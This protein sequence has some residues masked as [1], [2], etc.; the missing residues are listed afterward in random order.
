MKMNFKYAMMA[1]AISLGF[2][3]C[4]DN[5]GNVNLP[6]EVGEETYVQF[7][8]LQD[9]S[10]TRALYPEAP[11]EDVETT[12]NSAAVF[13]LNSN[14]VITKVFTFEPYEADGTTKKQNI[15]KATTGTYY[16]IA[17]ANVPS[18][19]TFALT[20]LIGKHL[21]N[22]NQVINGINASSFGEFVDQASVNKAGKKGNFFMTSGVEMDLNQDYK[23]IEYTTKE[24]KLATYD[25]I[26]ADGKLSNPKLNYVTIRIG[27]GVAKVDT[28]VGLQDDG[29]LLH[30]DAKGLIKPESI[31][32]VVTNNPNAMHFFP[33]FGGANLFQSPYHTA[34]PVDETQPTNYW[35]DLHDATALTYKTP[36]TKKGGSIISAK[37][38][39]YSY[40]VENTNAEPTYGNATIVSVKAQ[41][42]PDKVVLSG[43]TTESDNA[44]AVGTY[45]F[46][47]IR[48]NKLREDYYD[49]RF[50]L[51]A[52]DADDVAK[53]ELGLLD[54]EYVIEE[55]K[56]C[57]CY[58]IIPL[59]DELKEIT[60]RYDIVRNHYYELT[61]NKVLACGYSSPGG[62]IDTEEPDPLDPK[63]DT[64]LHVNLVVK[65]WT[66]VR[67]G[68]PLEPR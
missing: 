33:N 34:Y 63:K 54:G 16:F 25:Q 3:S 42:N 27:R 56:N 49:N 51:D 45:D 10:S 57:Y 5:E 68:G 52:N 13:M 36:F 48:N 64:Y 35:P 55:Y 1:A 19:A 47:R 50:F 32:Y 18:A 40:A 59:Y 9:N 67:Q 60:E 15:Y 58:Y 24:L 38:G 61:I 23:Q 31:E 6:E 7:D 14:K 62:D 8:L 11:A 4:S 37:G 22:L 30:V 66:R 17:V 26:V 28:S 2:A 46:Y 39:E 21:D 43:A 41:F 20:D 65:D 44:A 12:I 29:T 53:N